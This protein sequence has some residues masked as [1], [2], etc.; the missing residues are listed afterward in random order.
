MTVN[1]LIYFAY[2]SATQHATATFNGGVTGSY[3]CI[4]ISPSCTSTPID[5]TGL[6]ITNPTPCNDSCPPGYSLT[7]PGGLAVTTT[8]ECGT[9][10]YKGTQVQTCPVCPKYSPCSSGECGS[11]AYTDEC[12]QTCY[13]PCDDACPDGYTKDNTGGVTTTTACGTTCYGLPS[14]D[15]GQVL[16]FGEATTLDDGMTVK[17]GDAT[18]TP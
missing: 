12:G 8:T 9:T 15:R 6:V 4:A 14:T 13:K 3:K 1:G 18:A 5:C 7:N 10:C 17:S 2:A 16:D 11:I